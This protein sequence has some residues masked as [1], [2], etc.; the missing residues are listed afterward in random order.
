MEFIGSKTIETDRLILRATEKQDLKRLWEILCIPEV[1]RYYLIGKFN[2]EWEKELPWQMKK[3]KHAKDSDVFQ[4][5]VILKEENKCIGQVCAQKN[6]EDESIRDVGWFIDPEFQRQ[7]YAYEATSTMLDYMF[8]E[9]KINA[10][11]TSVAICN[12]A[13]ENLM[14]KLGFI[15]RTDKTHI[16]H[17]TFGGVTPCYSYGLTKTEY[18]K[19]IS[20]NNQGSRLKRK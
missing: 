6:G 2:L 14:K 4:W 17:Y 5:S 11:E 20:T 10:I 9:V 16:V 18:K 13:S 8:N 7:K 1:N 19:H 12:P 3:L 15:K